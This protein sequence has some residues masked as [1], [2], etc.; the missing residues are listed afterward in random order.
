MSAMGVWAGRFGSRWRKWMRDPAGFADDLPSPLLRRLSLLGLAGGVLAS[1]VLA[2]ADRRAAGAWRRDRVGLVQTDGE[3]REFRFLTGQ[4]Q[5]PSAWPERVLIE[6]PGADLSAVVVAFGEGGGVLTAAEMGPGRRAIIAPGGRPVWT[7]IYRTDEGASLPEWLAARP[8]SRGALVA[9]LRAQGE[10][11]ASALRAAWPPMERRSTEPPLGAYRAWIER[12]EPGRADAERIRAGLGALTGLPRISVLMPV[13]DPD[14]AHLKAA[15][16]SVL[17]QIHPDFRLCIADDGSRLEAVRSILGAAAE[18]PRVRLV[19]RPGEGVAAATNAALALA[20]GEVALFLDHDDVLA[21]HALATI[22]AAFAERPGAAAVYSDEDVIDAH[23]RRS[24]PVFKPDLDRERLLA[25]NYVNHA[26]AV[27]LDLLRRLGGLRCGLEGAQDHDLVLRVAESGAG[28]I[29]HLPHVL[30]H[31]RIFPGGGSFSQSA[32]PRIDKARVQVAQEHLARTGRPAAL[33]PGPRGHLIVG[34]P[35]PD[36][37]PEVT[38]IIPT[39]DHPGLLEACVAGLLEQTDYPALR[40]C[41]VDNGSRT[42]RALRL[43]DRLERTPRV[44]VLRIDA[45]FNFS[46][47]NNAAVKTA[48]TELVA[49]VN[50]DVIVVEPGWLKAMAALA[51]QPDVG[52]VG[53]KLFYPDGRIQH[54]GIVL[55]VGPHRVA[56]HEFRGAPGASPGPQNRL[57]LTREASAVTAACMVAS[58]SRFLEVGGFDEERFAVAFNDVDLCLKLRQAG[59]RILWTPQARLM[60]L[61]SASRG[62]DK[63]KAASDRLTREARLMHERW[64]ERL[65]EDPFYNPNLTLVDESFTLAFRSRAKAGWRRPG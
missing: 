51:A 24:A 60:H 21:P 18:D 48:D 62:S 41:I 6:A 10:D 42:E 1:D 36:P 25:Q 29:L 22:A 53:A 37:P 2:E 46:A 52:A 15:I 45:P 64:G 50:D 7:R 63:L 59:Y 65:A 27:R 34:H 39:R 40:L 28:P 43:L 57:L 5:P 16:R 26:F 30:Y 19:R 31:W 54:A 17:D 38:A 13:H 32:R 8:L 55:G 61:E 11:L 12:N 35:L 3:R 23:G 56:G 58:R 47:L 49:F 4:G 33:T 14:P 9:H 44:K 20:E